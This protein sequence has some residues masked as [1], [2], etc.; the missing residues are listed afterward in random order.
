MNNITV[1]CSGYVDT[2]TGPTD[3]DTL[4]PKLI[5]TVFDVFCH[6]LPE[7]TRK[8]LWFGV[9][10]TEVCCYCM[11]LSI[12]QFLLVVGTLIGNKN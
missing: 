7:K 9:K 8:R 2:F 6:C 5:S 1:K 12:N 10:H 3:P 11:C 4:D